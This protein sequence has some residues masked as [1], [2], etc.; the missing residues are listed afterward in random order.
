LQLQPNFEENAGARAT[1]NLDELVESFVVEH[2]DERT[3]RHTGALPHRLSRVLQQAGQRVHD[4]GVLGGDVL[5]VPLQHVL[6]DVKA[7]HFKRDLLGVRFVAQTDDQALGQASH[8]GLHT[9][10]A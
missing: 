4:V 10:A 7:D 6:H 2:R 5:R 1:A 8:H 3:E 9:A